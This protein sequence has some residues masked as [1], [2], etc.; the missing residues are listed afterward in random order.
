MKDIC[1][2]HLKKKSLKKL[3][4][5]RGLE[6]DEVGVGWGNQSFSVLKHKPK[7]GVDAVFLYYSYNIAKHIS[8][9]IDFST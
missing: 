3:A 9:H 2:T 1:H 8:L 4:H 7:V 5:S 6:G